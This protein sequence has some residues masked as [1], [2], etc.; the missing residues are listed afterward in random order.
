M[1]E[2]S[3]G[4]LIFWG[5]GDAM[6]QALLDLLKWLAHFLVCLS[7]DPHSLIYTHIPVCEILATQT[8]S[9]EENCHVPDFLV[10]A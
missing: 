1:R 10:R 4:L 7:L 6:C 5:D 9:R 8:R 3:E 2:G